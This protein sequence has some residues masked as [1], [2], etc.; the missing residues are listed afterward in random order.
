MAKPEEV[1]AV[2]GYQVGS[3]SPFGLPAPLPILVDES[4]LAQQSVSIGS[5]VRATTIFI[6]TKDLQRALGKYQSGSFAS[7]K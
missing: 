6:Q 2:T 4:V 3:V 5:G 1:L 7:A